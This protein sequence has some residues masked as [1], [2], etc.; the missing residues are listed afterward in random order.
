LLVRLENESDESQIG[1]G[2]W[3]SITARNNLG[4]RNVHVQ[5]DNPTDGFA[6]LAFLVVGSDDQDGLRIES[7]FVKERVEVHI[8]I[9]ALPW[10]DM[11]FIEKVGAARPKYGGCNGE[12]PALEL[13]STLRGAAIQA[14]TDVV[15]ARLLSLRNG[16]ATIAMTPGEALVI[17]FLRLTPGTRLPV[18][19]RVWKPAAGKKRRFVHVA[20]FSG[21][22]RAG[23]VSLE[24]RPITP[25]ERREKTRVKT[26]P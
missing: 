15:G 1:A 11:K 21:G 24:L 7:E 23:G 19:I 18:R 10:R 13:Q 9:Q 4:L 22:R 20:Q 26:R 5:P 8:P 16:M 6:D 3:T 25:Q 17:P 14:K 12:D 2:G